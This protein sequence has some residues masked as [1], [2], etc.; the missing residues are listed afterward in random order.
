MIEAV[1]IEIGEELTGQV[2]NGKAA[3]PPVRLEQIVA[4][5]M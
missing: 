2:A 1:E 4:G 5:K 3:P